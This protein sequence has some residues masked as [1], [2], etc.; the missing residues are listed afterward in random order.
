MT[1]GIFTSASN[2][3]LKGTPQHQPDLQNIFPGNCI[4]QKANFK[5][6]FVNMLRVGQVHYRVRNMFMWGK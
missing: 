2:Y 4:S 6:I 5:A 3:E 1:D